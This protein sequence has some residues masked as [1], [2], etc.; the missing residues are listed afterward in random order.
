MTTLIR[1]SLK[2]QTNLNTLLEK[3]E[4]HFR[5]K[6]HKQMAEE[7]QV[8]GCHTL[9]AWTEHFEKGKESKKL[10]YNFSLSFIY[11]FIIIIFFFILTNLGF[12]R[13]GLGS[14]YYVILI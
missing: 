3:R 8:I 2:Y 14:D 13:L 12:Q 6:Q 10:V 11:L 5:N 7:N 4:S 1:S 9:E